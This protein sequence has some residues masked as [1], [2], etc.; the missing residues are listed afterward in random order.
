MVREGLVKF[1]LCLEPVTPSLLLAVSV[2]P[3]FLLTSAV[4]V[5]SQRPSLDFILSL[6]SCLEK[7]VF[8]SPL[9]QLLHLYLSWFCWVPA[10]KVGPKWLWGLKMG[11]IPGLQITPVTKITQNHLYIDEIMCGFSLHRCQHKHA[12]YYISKVSEFAFFL[13]FLRKK[14]L[15]F[16]FLTLG[17]RL[18]AV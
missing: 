17:F 7:S 1:S 10:W 13:V 9:C 8:H 18:L 3:H 6:H 5:K 15:W 2:K 12:H 16:I 11:T 4:T 14:L